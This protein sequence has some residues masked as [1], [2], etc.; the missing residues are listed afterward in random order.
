M[1]VLTRKTEQAIIIDGHT[2]V[3]ILAVDGESTERW[4]LYLAVARIRGPRGTDVAITVR[5]RNGEAETLPV[6][7]DRIVVPAVRAPPIQDA[8]GDPVNDIAYLIITKFN[9]KTHSELLRFLESITNAGLG[10]LIIDVR[11][12]PGGR[13]DPR[14]GGDSDQGHHQ[15]GG[16]RH[17][18]HAGERAL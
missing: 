18:G 17:E 9:E 10:R 14:D 4:S 1:L 11:G 2:I 13:V 8:Q 5:H 16:Q 6:T 15:G 3:R 7:R 12:N